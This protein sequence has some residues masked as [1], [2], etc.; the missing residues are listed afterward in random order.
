M[1]WTMHTGI[2]AAIATVFA[3]YVAYFVPM[4][5]GAQRATAAGAILLISAVNYVG[6]KHG[7]RMQTAFTL[8]KLAAVGVIIVLGFAVGARYS[9]EA[10]ATAT[11]ATELTARGFVVGLIAGLFAFGGWHMVTYASE[12]TRDPQRTIPRALI[13]GTLIVTA[14][15]LALNAAYFH[16]LSR[17]AVI[18]SRQVA[19]D[20]ANAVFGGGGAAFLAALV[21][22]SSFGALSGVV[23]AGPRAYLAMARDGLFVP[24]AAEIHPVYR[25][26]HRAIVLQ[27][28]WA[29]VLIGTATYRELFTRVIYTEWLFFALMAL[30][31]MRLRRR[32]D[33]APA[34]RVWGYPWVPLVFAGSSLYIVANEVFSRFTSSMTGLA[35]VAA[36]L[37]VYWFLTRRARVATPNAD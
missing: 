11:G 2:A 1:F 13:I 24:W 17:S 4:S 19:A 10:A 36:G 16:L 33:Y 25:T 9:P 29:L 22:F 34:Y 14:C 6:V 15:Y 5:A 3:R 12:E 31:L 28:I 35:M 23:L 32:P 21:A 37:P 26:P 30:G 18:E 7:S 20:A 27:A 8:G